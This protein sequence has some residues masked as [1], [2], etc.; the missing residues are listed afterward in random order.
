MATA[1]GSHFCCFRD[2]CVTFKTLNLRALK[3][4]FRV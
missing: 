2:F 3:T 1:K 4:D